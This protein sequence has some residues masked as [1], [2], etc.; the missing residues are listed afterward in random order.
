MDRSIVFRAAFRL[1]EAAELAHSAECPK[2]EHPSLNLVLAGLTKHVKPI[3][4]HA[5]GGLI[6]NSSRVCTVCV[7][8]CVCVCDSVCLQFDFSMPPSTFT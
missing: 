5:Q 6:I 4:N 8:V 2:V 7:C 3:T 1:T